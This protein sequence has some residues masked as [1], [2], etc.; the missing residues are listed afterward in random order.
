MGYAEGSRPNVPMSSAY[1]VES[2]AIPRIPCVTPETV[3][4]RAEEPDQV[5]HILSLTSSWRGTDSP[6]SDCSEMTCR[7]GR[8][9]K[10]RRTYQALQIPGF[11]CLWQQLCPQHSYNPSY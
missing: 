11:T 7:L 4:I 3:V 2:P 8:I 5:R 10:A 9:H 6:G 1:R